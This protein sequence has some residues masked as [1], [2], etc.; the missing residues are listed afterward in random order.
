MVYAIFKV[1]IYCK[2]HL[3]KNN[4]PNTATLCSF[5]TAPLH[6]TNIEIKKSSLLVFFGKYKQSF[7]YFVTY[8]LTLYV[9]F[10]G[11]PGDRM[12]HNLIIIYM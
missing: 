3:L 8:T 1:C 6:Y 10:R 9:G 11:F 4:Q 2:P 7:K 5:K 12:L